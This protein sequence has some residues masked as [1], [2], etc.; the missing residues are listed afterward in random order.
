MKI[1]YLT[2]FSKK[3]LYED[4]HLKRK[5]KFEV[6]LKEKKV[7]LDKNLVRFDSCIIKKISIKEISIDDYLFINEYFLLNGAMISDSS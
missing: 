3:K 1:L 6:K 4:K 2:F 5:V 7:N